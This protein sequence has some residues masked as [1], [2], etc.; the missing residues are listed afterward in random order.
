M[1]R[2]ICCRCGRETVHLSVARASD[3]AGV[4]RATMYNWINR[5]LV[6]T[7]VRPSGRKFVC[8]ESLVRQYV[9]GPGLPAQVNLGGLSVALVR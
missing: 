1:P 6:H 2:Y 5:D 3:V 8:T 4:T 7:V 9:P